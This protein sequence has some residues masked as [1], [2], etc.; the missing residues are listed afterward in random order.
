MLLVDCDSEFV[1]SSDVE[2]ISNYTIKSALLNRIKDEVNLIIFL[3][4]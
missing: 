4:P 2:S 3:K 1:N